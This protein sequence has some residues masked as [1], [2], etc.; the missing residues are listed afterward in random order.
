[1]KDKFEL[2]AKED[3]LWDARGEGNG[4]PIIVGKIDAIG[5]LRGETD[6]I[7]DED[8]AVPHTD[9]DLDNL[10]KVL[11]KERLEIREYSAFGDPNWQITDAQIE[12]CE[13]AKGS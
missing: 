12:I 10:I 4:D 11:R 1:M 2:R 7:T 9:E 8:I 13:W 5:F 6:P 3:K